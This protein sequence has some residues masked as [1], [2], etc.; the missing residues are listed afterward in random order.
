MTRAR[1]GTGDRGRLTSE[2]TQA[3]MSLSREGGPSNRP[4]DIRGHVV[5]YTL[6]RRRGAYQIFHGALPELQSSSS[7]FFSFSVSM[8]DQ[9]P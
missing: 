7:E 1:P 8:Q 6:P 5:G 4:E 3:G 2:F 9:K